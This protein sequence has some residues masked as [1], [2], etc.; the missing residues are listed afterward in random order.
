MCKYIYIFLQVHE[1]TVPN[2]NEAQN[3]WTYEDHKRLACCV[4]HAFQ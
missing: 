2:A 1:R 4:I 3:K